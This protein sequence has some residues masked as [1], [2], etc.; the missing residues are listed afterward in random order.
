MAPYLTLETTL[1][2]DQ[3]PGLT[4]RPG[5]HQGGPGLDPVPGR[6]KN[7]IPPWAR[8]VSPAWL[9]CFHKTRPH[10]QA[11][12]QPFVWKKRGL[13][14]LT[15]SRYALPA[16]LRPCIPTPSFL[17]T[18]RASTAQFRRVSS[19]GGE[20]LSLLHLL[21]SLPFSF[22]TN[23]GTGAHSAQA[24]AAVPEVKF[25]FLQQAAVPAWPAVSLSSPLGSCGPSQ[26]SFPQ[27]SFPRT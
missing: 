1:T 11:G 18:F 14:V 17:I 8:A 25:P 16:H 21:L 7:Y 15:S 2:I 19:K 12:S 27:G 20:T 13:L 3:G 26:R 6:V 22:H 5:F 24:G 23:Q 9:S 10:P 4:P